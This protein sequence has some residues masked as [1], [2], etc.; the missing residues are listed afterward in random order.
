MSLLL[1]GT[2]ARESATK[3]AIKSLRRAP[4]TGAGSLRNRCYLAGYECDLLCEPLT[5][6]GPARL[7]QF[8]AARA[9]LLVLGS[10]AVSVLSLLLFR[11][12]LVNDPN[13][14]LIWS[15]D[16]VHGGVIHAFGG[17][18]TAWKPLP[19]LVLV[20][21]QLIGGG[22]AAFAW[23][24]IARASVLVVS[25]LLFRSAARVGG[26]LGGLVA[27]L[28]PFLFLSWVRGVSGGMIEPMAVALLLAAVEA[29]SSG[30]RRWA[31]WFGVSA[32]LVRPEIAPIPGL[33]GLWLLRREGAGVLRHLAAALLLLLLAW[34]GLMWLLLDDPI[35]IVHRAQ[36]WPHASKW[37]LPLAA[38]A[39]SNPIELIGLMVLA[40]LGLAVALRNHEPV[41]L[42]AAA[43]GGGWL[44]I[45]GLMGLTGSP[46]VPRYV[47]GGLVVLCVLVGAGAGACVS[48]SPN[49]AIALVGFVFAIA[50]VAWPVSQRAEHIVDIARAG[51]RLHL[52]VE[53]ATAAISAAG[54]VGRFEPCFPIGGNR[55]FSRPWPYG[56]LARRLGLSGGTT[57]PYLTAPTVLVIGPP[58]EAGGRPKR[59][60]GE[61]G[62]RLIARRDEWSVVYVAGPKD[63]GAFSLA[64]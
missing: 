31:F 58:G 2:V 46:A 44:A 10:I 51:S 47:L 53:G 9:A 45:V 33:Y 42:G 13:V 61:R 50:A 37:I 30:R 26:A 24:V 32:C 11:T 21:F 25:V 60:P 62:R 57:L 63:C 48:A 19:T 20:P 16:L 55:D 43:V 14:W 29:N 7:R 8:T 56:V 28:C 22:A 39:V 54:G 34:P 12:E 5:A 38:D 3:P 52:A 4:L 6:F 23:A 35:Q 18:S 49:R 15:H 64:G 41:V 27:A 36:G 17:Q 1:V 59:I 40:A